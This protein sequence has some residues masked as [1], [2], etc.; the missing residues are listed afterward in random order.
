MPDLTANL[1]AIRRALSTMRCTCP[2]TI[3]GC[4]IL[5]ATC[6]ACEARKALR[7]LEGVGERIAELEAELTAAW[8]HIESAYDIEPRAYF[9]EKYHN[10]G[11][12]PLQMAI[13]YIWK[14]DQK[15]SAARQQTADEAIK[16]VD[17]L[18]EEAEAN[19]HLLWMPSSAIST[20]QIVAAKLR[21]HFGLEGR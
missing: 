4:T 11:A 12:T 21:E 7:E 15:A 5:S 20:I 6:P 1:E 18:A 16:V 13:H 19:A 14:R 17:K 10:S 2:R 9:E 3:H 8:S